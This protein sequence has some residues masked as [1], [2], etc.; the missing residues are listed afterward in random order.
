MQEFL[1]YVLLK[2]F[3]SN[4]RHRLVPLFILVNLFIIGYYI[5]KD[6]RDGYRNRTL[7][8]DDYQNKTKAPFQLHYS[9]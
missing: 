5:N 8:G 9:Y 7:K 6:T 2:K 3:D 4:Q 1:T